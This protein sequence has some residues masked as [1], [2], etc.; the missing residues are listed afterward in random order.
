MSQLAQ[1]ARDVAVIRSSLQT[2]HHSYNHSALTRGNK[3]V[4]ALAKTMESFNNPFTDE[5]QDLF[6]L[7]TK[8]V[9]PD[10]IKDDLC[11]QPMIGQT[12]FDTFVKERIQSGKITIWSTMSK[13]KVL[14]WKSRAK[15]VKVS[16]KEKVIE[17]R[18]D[19][20]LFAR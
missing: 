13:R 1:Q 2:W 9:M 7:A 17:L 4:Q 8:V 10:N 19:K 15:K 18:E 11:N 16:A 20:Y 3:T 5:S 6:N 12:L 14:T